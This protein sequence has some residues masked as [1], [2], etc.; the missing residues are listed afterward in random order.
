MRD[1]QVKLQQRQTAEGHP[2]TELLFNWRDAGDV[3]RYACARV[4]WTVADTP[5]DRAR[6]VQAF[7]ARQRA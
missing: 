7:M 4:W 1:I 6:E 2:F 5:M 3:I